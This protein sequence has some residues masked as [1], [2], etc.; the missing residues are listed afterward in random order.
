MPRSTTKCAAHQLKSGKLPKQLG[1]DTEEWATATLERLQRR[2]K[3]P[4]PKI[5]N[6]LAVVWTPVARQV[7]GEYF[8]RW[9]KYLEYGDI[10]QECMYALS[11]AVADLAQHPKT[12]RIGDPPQSWLATTVRRTVSDRMIPKTL[13]RQMRRQSIRMRIRK[14]LEQRIG[15]PCTEQELADALGM[16]VQRLQRH[17]HGYVKPVGDPVVHPQVNFEAEHVKVRVHDALK[18]LSEQQ[19]F[20][21]HLYFFQDMDVWDISREVNLKR[22]HVRAQLREIREQLRSELI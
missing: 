9:K 2:K 4:G 10:F 13:R 15:Q 12:Y 16:K 6:R 1:S 20:I 11:I 7:A 21:A 5:R 17:R 18:T 22:Y 19:Q 3:R 14:D 8:R